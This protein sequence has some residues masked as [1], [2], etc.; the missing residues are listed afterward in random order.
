[1][2]MGFHKMIT[3]RELIIGRTVDELDSDM[4]Q[5][6]LNAENMYQKDLY[7][8]LTCIG[9]RLSP[10]L[11]HYYFEE[12]EGEPEYWVSILKKLIRVYRLNPLM[13]YTG[14]VKIRQIIP[15]VKTLIEDLKIKLQ[16]AILMGE[17]K[18]DITRED[19]AKY[20]EIN[21]Y[22]RFIQYAIYY[23]TTEDFKSFKRKILEESNESFYEEPEL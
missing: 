2:S 23:I 3:D 6:D 20:L 19:F 17:I 5:E 14:E 15:Y 18:K 8:F 22:G 9:H 4:S 1:M 12:L 13:S 10:S 7:D 11:I 21:G 16:E